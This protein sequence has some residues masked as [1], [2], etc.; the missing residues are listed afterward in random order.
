MAKIQLSDL[1]SEAAQATR[2]VKCTTC[3][4]IAEL[5]PDDSAALIAAVRSDDV[6]AGVIAKALSNYGYSV[7]PSAV[8]RHRRECG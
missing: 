1:L 8:S 7:S 5:E 6:S 2:V 3:K 4:L